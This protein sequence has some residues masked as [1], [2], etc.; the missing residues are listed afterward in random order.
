MNITHP[1]PLH[2]NGARVRDAL[3]SAGS[4]ADIVETVEASPTA[5]AA[6]AQ[7]DVEVAQIANS[8]I[9]DADG[10]PVLILTSGAHR[11]DTDHVARVIGAHSLQ[12]ASATFVREATGQ[13]IG[14]VAPL[15]HP[16]P[17]RTY[18]DVAL[19]QWPVIWAAGGHPHYVF[20]T[21][22]DELR[23]LT[24]ALEISVVVSDGQ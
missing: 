14:G 8:L 22:F 2:P 17:V 15:G 21:S 18:I 24:G 4:S 13:P 10:Q 1:D 20:A 19:G 3:R 6:A 11:V 23:R 16:H 5:A 7:L 9:F 12:R